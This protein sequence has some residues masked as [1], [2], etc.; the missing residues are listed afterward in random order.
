MTDTEDKTEKTTT[1]KTVD[2]APYMKKDST[3]ES[4]KSNVVMPTVLLIVAVIVIAATFYKGE[5]DGLIAD[6][7][8]DADTAVISTNED[9]AIAND[10][11]DNMD[12]PAINEQ[13]NISPEE[14]IVWAAETPPQVFASTTTTDEATTAEQTKNDDIGNNSTQA[15]NNYSVTEYAGTPY[16]NRPDILNPTKSDTQEQAQKYNEAMQKRRQAFEQAM[17]AR[18]QQYEASMKIQQQKREALIA[19]QKAQFQRMEQNRQETNKKIQEL[20]K[21]ISQLHKEIHML[22]SESL[23]NRTSAAA[24]LPPV[25]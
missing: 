13:A 16:Q 25:Y 7:N 23:P 5:H 8:S 22:M 11:S 9:I 20:H 14:T 10:S 24:K 6:T 19:E 15:A 4:S 21:Q 17:E 1:E 3:T 12:T 2:T 18:R